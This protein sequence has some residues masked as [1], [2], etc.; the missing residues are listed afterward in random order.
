MLYH[1]LCICGNGKPEYYK[2]IK[3]NQIENKKTNTTNIIKKYY[4]ISTNEATELSKIMN[5]E[6]VI[7][8]AEDLGEHNLINKIRKEFK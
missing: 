1:I 2:W 8:M 6:S 7:E 4:N 3:K 5:L